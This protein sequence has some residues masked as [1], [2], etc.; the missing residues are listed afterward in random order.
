M[1]DV[2]EPSDVVEPRDVVE[3]S[4]VVELGD[5]MLSQ[6]MWLSQMW[7]GWAMMDDH[8]KWSSHH[9]CRAYSHWFSLFTGTVEMYNGIRKI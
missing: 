8:I 9:D 6:V 7:C 3:P 2:V 4:D 1:C 5:V